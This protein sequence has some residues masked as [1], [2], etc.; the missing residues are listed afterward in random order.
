[1]N[2]IY[3]SKIDWKQFV[4]KKKLDARL[5]YNRKDG[6]IDQQVFLKSAKQKQQ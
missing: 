4:K 6:Y 1:M 2:S 5:R 3:K